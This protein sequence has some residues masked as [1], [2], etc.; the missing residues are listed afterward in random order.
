MEYKDSKKAPTAET[1]SMAFCDIGGTLYKVGRNQEA[2]AAYKRAVKVW[3]DNIVAYYRISEYYLGEGEEKLAFQAYVTAFS[4]KIGSK[5]H[6]NPK[7]DAW[8]MLAYYYAQSN[9]PDDAMRCKRQSDALKQE[10]STLN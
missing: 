4:S 8:G 9:K 10:S 7:A 5:Y 6:P 1:K 3:P 2:L